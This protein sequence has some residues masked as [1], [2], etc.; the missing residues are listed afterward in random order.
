ML[1]YKHVDMGQAAWIKW[2]SYHYLARHWQWQALYSSP[3]H[4]VLTHFRPLL[5]WLIKIF[6]RLTQKVNYMLCA[7]AWMITATK[8]LSAIC[9]VGGV[10]G[11]GLGRWQSP[12]PAEKKSLFSIIRRCIIQRTACSVS[13]VNAHPQSLEKSFF[14][15][16]HPFSSVRLF[17]YWFR[18]LAYGFRNVHT[19][20]NHFL[21]L[22]YC[23]CARSISPSLMISSVRAHGW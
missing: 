23:A 10:R 7:H 6:M 4:S 19:V 5:L 12:S 3:S 18:P 11:R 17:V 20:Y 22:I 9:N 1:L 16:S 2:V 14:F 15:S 8:W 21:L 13:H